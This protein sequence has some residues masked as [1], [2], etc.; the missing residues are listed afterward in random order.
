MKAF[1]AVGRRALSDAPGHHDHNKQLLS[2]MR[3]LAPVAFLGIGDW[4]GI[5]TATNGQRLT[6]VDAKQ[7]IL[8]AHFGLSNK[9][10]V[11]R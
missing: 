4:L 8:L 1:R 2:K 9:K 11:D 5:S 7:D 3:D 6:S 10:L